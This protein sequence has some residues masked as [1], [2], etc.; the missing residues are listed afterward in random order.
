MNSK[1]CI[2]CGKLKQLSE[3]HVLQSGPR[4]GKV[5]GH[6]YSCKRVRAKKYA[7]QNMERHL[8]YHRQWKAKNKQKCAEYKKR[9]R[10]KP[11]VKEYE[12]EK[13]REYYL[14]H[15]DDLRARGS[16][17]AKEWAKNNPF[18]RSC[19]EIARRT[20]KQ[21]IPK[22]ANEFF[23]SEVYELARKR[24]NMMGFVWHVDH[25]VPLTSKRVCGLH[26]EFNLQVIPGSANNAKGNRHWPD[27]P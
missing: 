22:W 7:M 6:C 18:R 3:F 10:S 23:I 19:I 12:R 15:I 11:G 8:E 27:M 4:K 26:C 21:R 16:K 13:A 17:A 20:A 14:A 1:T 2:D 5:W 24:T 25:I 9:Y